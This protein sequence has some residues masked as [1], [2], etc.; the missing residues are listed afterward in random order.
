MCFLCKISPQHLQMILRVQIMATDICVGNV[1]EYNVLNH[2]CLYMYTGGERGGGSVCITARKAWNSL[3]LQ[4]S[5]Y[6]I[7]E[8]TNQLHSSM[9]ICSHTVAPLEEMWIISGCRLG[10]CTQLTVL[11]GM[12]RCSTEK[13]SC[14]A[15][16]WKGK[17]AVSKAGLTGILGLVPGLGVLVWGCWSLQKW[18]KRGRTGA[19]SPPCQQHLLRVGGAWNFYLA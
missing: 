6:F 19:E 8:T 15:P 3:T 5:F 4:K 9:A 13:Q 17:Q 10:C 11:G 16:P 7:A 14:S 18:I 1:L 12:W 2:V